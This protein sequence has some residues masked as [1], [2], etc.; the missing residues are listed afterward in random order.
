M[1]RGHH[2]VKG[3]S[4]GEIGWVNVDKQFQNPGLGMSHAPWEKDRGVEAVVAANIAGA[5]PFDAVEHER[6]V[7]EASEDGS[8]TVS[9]YGSH[10]SQNLLFARFDFAGLLVSGIEDAK[11]S[12]QFGS[13]KELVKSAT[14]GNGE[15]TSGKA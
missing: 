14:G 5:Q 7:K 10:G 3:L 12:L 2:E 11:T 1:N 8:T 6:G 9:T 13:D 4:A 15:A